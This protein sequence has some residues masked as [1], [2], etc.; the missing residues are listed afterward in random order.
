MPP[1]CKMPGARAS[2]DH[3][4]CLL[5]RS[6]AGHR[7]T[8]DAE[9]DSCRVDGHPPTFPASDKTLDKPVV[10][11]L[12]KPSP[13]MKTPLTCALLISASSLLLPHMAGAQA[14]PFDTNP[15]PPPPPAVTTG[16]R[17]PD[18][19]AMQD[20]V[21]YIIQNGVVTR[22]SEERVMRISPNGTVTG[23]DGRTWIIPAGQVVMAD[24]R[25]VPVTPGMFASGA[26]SPSATPASSS[27]PVVNGD[28]RSGLAPAGSGTPAPSSGGNISGAPGASAPQAGVGAPTTTGGGRTS[29]MRGSGTNSGLLDAG[30]P[31]IVPPANSGDASQTPNVPSQVPGGDASTQPGV[32][33]IPGD[34]SAGAQAPGQQQPGADAPNANSGNPTPNQMRSSGAPNAGGNATPNQLRSRSA[35]NAGSSSTPNQQNSSGAPT[36]QAGPGTGASP[37]APSTNNPNAVRTTQNP[38]NSPQGNAGPGSGSGSGSGT[39]A[40]TPASGSGSNAASGSRPGSGSSRSGSGS[41]GSSSSSRS[42]GGSSGGSSGGGTAPR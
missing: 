18:G 13:I 17:V 11:S 3:G 8:P 2:R 40:G 4:H 1:R 9:H 39:S 34:S 37:N 25:T 27:S 31:V 23:F 32:L 15:A 41:G 20:G 10:S 35:P 30:I 42:G 29:S 36:P 33:T 26:Q 38:S 12:E 28:N 5:S 22:V 6:I 7:S 14:T 19:I 16:A 21:V 24:G